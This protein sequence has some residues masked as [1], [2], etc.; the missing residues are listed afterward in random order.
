MSSRTKIILNILLIFIVVGLMAW[1]V[2][3]EGRHPLLYTVTIYKDGQAIE[4]YEHQSIRNM[5]DCSKDGIYLLPAKIYIGGTN[6]SSY[7][8]QLEERE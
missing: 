1:A 2:Y 8:L 6:G 5:C 4:R 7:K 3:E